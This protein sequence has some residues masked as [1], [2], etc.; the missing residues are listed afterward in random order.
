MFGHKKSFRKPATNSVSSILW[1]KWETRIDDIYA[2][3]RMKSHREH[4]SFQTASSGEVIHSSIEQAAGIACD[5]SNICRSH[6]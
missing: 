2:S 1:M 3:T 6:K 4:V 5:D